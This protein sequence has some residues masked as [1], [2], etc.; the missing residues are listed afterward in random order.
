MALG[1]AQSLSVRSRLWTA[2]VVA[3]LVVAGA[4]VA[5]VKVKLVNKVADWIP[6]SSRADGPLATAGAVSRAAK[7]SCC[8]AGEAKANPATA[9]ATARCLLETI[10]ELGLSG[11]KGGLVIQ[12]LTVTNERAL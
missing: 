4:V 8:G 9:A 11:R 3:T 1:D 7:S 6:S 10:S 5:A 2:G 12:C